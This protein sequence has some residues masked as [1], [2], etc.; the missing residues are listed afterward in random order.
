MPRRTSLF[1]LN[2]RVRVDCMEFLM[3]VLYD[4][5]AVAVL[6]ISVNSCAKVGFAQTVT[7]IIGR[8]ASFFGALFIGKAGSQLIYKLFLDNK[9]L[10]FLE[11][12]VADSVSADDILESLS[13]AA[14]TLPA[15]MANFYGLTSTELEESIGNSVLDAVTV[16]E[17]QIVEP[18]VTG[19]LHIVIFLIAFA[20]FSFLAKRFSEAVG[21]VFKL[22]IIKTADRFAGGLLGVV[23]GGINL[24]LIA[25]V[26][27]FVLYFLSD[28]P[29][30]FNESLIMDTLIWSRVYEF[31][32]FE[33]LK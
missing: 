19:F 12:T 6:L 15:F 20:V 5:I 2:L 22:P 1:V 24:Y 27:R 21:F 8:I 29:A 3:L 26:L 28:P 9:I 4:A 16:L 32:P 13:E 25:L 18:A 33:F 10:R 11:E 17:Q 30:L 7:G 31:N 14:D 23:Q